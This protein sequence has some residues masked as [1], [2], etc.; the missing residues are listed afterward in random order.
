MWCGGLVSAMSGSA[1]C[2]LITSAWGLRGDWVASVIRGCRAADPPPQPCGATL[3][4]PRMVPGNTQ[5]IT[6][7]VKSRAPTHF[8]S[9]G[10]INIKDWL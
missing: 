9:T 6:G 2:G 1:S 5:V 3:A 10:A 8:S 4:V 7:E